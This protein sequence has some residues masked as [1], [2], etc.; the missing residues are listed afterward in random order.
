LFAHR[1]PLTGLRNRR[2]A[3][4]RKRD[5]PDHRLGPR[6]PQSRAAWLYISEPRGT[7]SSGPTIH[8]RGPFR[9]GRCTGCVFAR[10]PVAKIRHGQF[11]P[12]PATHR[13]DRGG[14]EFVMWLDGSPEGGRTMRAAP[15]PILSPVRPARHPVSGKPA[16]AVKGLSIGA[17]WRGTPQT[18]RKGGRRKRCSRAKVCRECHARKA[19]EAEGRFS[20]M[21]R[22]RA[23]RGGRKNREATAMTHHDGLLRSACSGKRE[24]R[25]ADS[26]RRKSKRLSGASH[27]DPAERP[28][29]SP[30]K[31]DGGSRRLLLFP[32]QRSGSD[33]G[34]GRVA[35]KK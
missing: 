25:T 12:G 19:V 1:D 7:I 15:R 20:H 34:A 28:P 29:A 33:G 3:S 11:A 9:A 30:Q 23:H 26:I 4:P 24:P 21:A 35:G 17:S 32:R 18:G 8:K 6:R 31:H 10:E 13:P 16:A 14:D 22:T 27:G 2:E 5:A